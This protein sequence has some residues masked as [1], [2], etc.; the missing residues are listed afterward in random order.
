M[1]FSNNHQPSPRSPQQAATLIAMVLPLVA[2]EKG[3]IVVDA[4]F[5]I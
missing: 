5:L 3:R 4:A 1:F 2:H